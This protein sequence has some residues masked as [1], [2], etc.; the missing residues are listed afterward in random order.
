MELT[1]RKIGNVVVI[2]LKIGLHQR[3][4]YEPLQQLVRGH[5]AAGQ[6]RFILNLAGCEWID[7]SGLGELIKLLVAVMRQGGNLKLAA[8]PHKMKGIMAVT[9][10]TQVFEI[11]DSEQAALESFPA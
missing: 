5:L 4:Q 10:L 9:N 8:V 2:D 3:G 1:E 7:S 6:P 11:F